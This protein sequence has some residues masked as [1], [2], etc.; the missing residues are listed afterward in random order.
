MLQCTAKT[1]LHQV[2]QKT[3]VGCFSS[4]INVLWHI[5]AQL[6]T[7]KHKQGLALN[8]AHMSYWSHVL[9]CCTC[10]TTLIVSFLSEMLDSSSI[11]KVSYSLGGPPGA[12]CY[13]N[14]AAVR[15]KNEATCWDVQKSE[16]SNKRSPSAPL[17]HRISFATAAVSS[18][19]PLSWAILSLCNN[20]LRFSQTSRSFCLLKRPSNLRWSA[21]LSFGLCCWDCWDRTA[22]FFKS[23]GILEFSLIK[24][25]R[26]K[27]RLDNTL[28]K[29]KE[30]R[31]YVSKL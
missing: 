5:Y 29:Y 31:L 25:I 13:F 28:K 11:A 30:K 1:V 16:I 22:S 15:E 26:S 24:N 12:V 4:S 20:L 14:S 8:I 2:L 3:N 6:L 9:G 21:C 27:Q 10:N 18:F 23:C 17:A 7:Q 19:I